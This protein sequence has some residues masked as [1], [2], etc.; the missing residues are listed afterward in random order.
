MKKLIKAVSEAIGSA[1]PTK[2]LLERCPNTVHAD[3][4]TLCL[5]QPHLSIKG[6]WKLDGYY[7]IVCPGLRKSTL[8]LNGEP[9]SQWF[10][11]HKI[12]SSPTRVSAFIPKGAEQIMPLTG[13]ELADLAGSPRNL[14]FFYYDVLLNLPKTFPQ[15]KLKDKEGVIT[16]LT[17]LPLTELEIT[18]FKTAVKRLNEEIQL[19]FEYREALEDVEMNLIQQPLLLKPARTSFSGDEALKRI[20]EEDEDF[21][22]GM[23]NQLLASSSNR[24]TFLQTGWLTGSASCLVPEYAQPDNIRYY[25][26]LYNCVYLRMPILE[27]H[28]SYL[29]ALGCSEKELVE[30]CSLGRIKLVLDQPLD[31]YHPSLVGVL[32]SLTPTQYILTRRLASVTVAD[33]RRRIPLLFPTLD[34]ETKYQFLHSAYK[35]LENKTTMTDSRAVLGMVGT[36]WDNYFERI[37][38][39]GTYGLVQTGAYHILNYFFAQHNRDY[40]VEIMDTAPGVNYAAAFGAHL[41]SRNSYNDE[42]LA[43]LIANMYSGLPKNFVLGNQPLANTAVDGVLVISNEVP[44]LDF[45]TSFHSG[46]IDRFRNIIYG[47]TKHVKS[48]EELHTSVQNF[49]K[50]VKHYAYYNEAKEVFDIRG[51][52]VDGATAAA[53]TS[54]PL[55]GWM[56]ERLLALL[57]VAGT[58]SKSVR[59]MRDYL[60]GVSAGTIPEAVLVARMRSNLVES[61]KKKK[62]SYE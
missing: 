15:F 45:A 32:L 8:A 11:K 4:E 14:T 12:L 28:R 58:R 36:L 57:S 52:L 13:E 49:N 48:E 40:A 56:I 26:T 31:R 19:R 46:D 3:Y 5:Q 37:Q 33:L 61:W 47:F 9:L 50:E 35:L 59:Q 51:F 7:F 60:E 10:A 16:V 42:P 1:K 30:L 27:H 54:V 53:D 20:W 2:N 18:Q 17:K 34:V 44:L 25:L 39:M 62:F 55:A 43:Q 41:I 22:M 21:W 38:R 29:A 23:K 24:D 6:I